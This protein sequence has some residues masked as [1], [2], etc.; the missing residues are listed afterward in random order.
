MEPLKAEI[1]K[2]EYI[3][4]HKCQICKKV[5]KN[6]TSQGDNFEEAVNNI[7]EAMGLYLE[8]KMEANLVCNKCS[9]SWISREVLEN[10][11]FPKQCPRCKSYD[12]NKKIKVN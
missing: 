11:N 2:G 8:D 12:W 9:Y 7:K 5:I 3:L 4:T 6:K 1:E 10:E